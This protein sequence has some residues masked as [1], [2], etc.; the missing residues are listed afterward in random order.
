MDINFNINLWGDNDTKFDLYLD[1]EQQEI[2]AHQ[3]GSIPCAA[4]TNVH[5]S[6]GVRISGTI[7]IHN[8]L[9]FLKGESETLEKIINCFE[10]RLWDGSNHRGL[11][12]S[13]TEDL[14]YDLERKMD[15]EMTYYPEQYY[16]L[17]DSEE[18]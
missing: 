12:S 7:N 16:D 2:Y 18:E 6:I 8:L 5:K 15:H 13:E 14:L 9:G 17:E 1:P 10:G 4:H 3:K 11:W